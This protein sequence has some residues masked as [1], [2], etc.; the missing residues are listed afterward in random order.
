[1]RARSQC[2]APALGRGGSRR[3][4]RH[5]PT[6]LWMCW[7]LLV[8]VVGCGEVTPPEPPRPA[9]ITLESSIGDLV[10]VGGQTQL[11]AT[12]TDSE[13]NPN[14][15]TVSWSS[16]DESVV[17][18]TA[19]GL[20]TGVRAGTATVT[21]T[22]GDATRSLALRVLD[23]DLE[24][25]QVLLDDELAEAL[26]DGLSSTRRTAFLAAWSD[27]EAARL[28]GNL[29]AVRDCIADARSELGTSSTPA[30]RPLEAYLGLFIDWVERLLNL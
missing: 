21:A 11:L 2:M 16:S 1:M 23:A 24:T 17:T 5:G 4:G 22:A 20:A 13:G 9:S 7:S 19:G 6:F 12:V 27:C 28:S 3:R 14:S 8:L 10:A 18:V 15:G 26:I 29:T 25:I 30:S